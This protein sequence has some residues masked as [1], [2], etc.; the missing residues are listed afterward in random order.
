MNSDEEGAGKQ[1]DL[2]SQDSL[3]N[4]ICEASFAI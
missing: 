4:H 3:L 1:G 2:P